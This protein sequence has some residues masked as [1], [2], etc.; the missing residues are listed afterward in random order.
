MPGVEEDPAACQPAPTNKKSTHYPLFAILLPPHHTQAF[1][2]QPPS[3]PPLL[4]SLSLTDRK[5]G[6]PSNGRSVLYSTFKDGRYQCPHLEDQKN[7]S[8]RIS[9]KYR[10]DGQVSRHHIRRPRRE[11]GRGCCAREVDAQKVVKIHRLTRCAQQLH[12]RGDP[13][14]HGQ[15]GQHP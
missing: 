7:F 3:P 11:K 10:Q 5:A 6:N 13:W 9:S 4:F 12:G 14:S 15:P 8:P 2:V 1:E